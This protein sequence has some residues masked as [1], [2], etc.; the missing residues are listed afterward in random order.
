MHKIKKW[1]DHQLVLATS[2][3]LGIFNTQTGKCKR[4]ILL[5]VKELMPQT[6]II[7]CLAITTRN[8][9]IAGSYTEVFVF[10]E[11]LRLVTSLEAGYTPNDISKERLRFSVS[12][13][14][15][16]MVMH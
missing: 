6:N 9:I 12:I 11:Q 8:E 7:E 14:I 2:E 4:I 5:A 3:G 10:D 13:D 16:P 15:F 1:K